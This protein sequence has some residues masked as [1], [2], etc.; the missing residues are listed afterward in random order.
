[1]DFSLC[2]FPMENGQRREKKKKR[3]LKGGE[4]LESLERI[5]PF[6][7]RW[8][9]HT[10][11]TNRRRRTRRAEH[12]KSI[13]ENLPTR[14]LFCF[15]PAIPKKRSSISFMLLLFFP[16]FLYSL[17]S[18]LLHKILTRRRLVSKFFFLLFFFLDEL[19]I[20]TQYIKLFSLSLLLLLLLS[21]LDLYF[22]SAFMTAGNARRNKRLEFHF[23]EARFDVPTRYSCGKTRH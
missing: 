10:R 6:R 19:S 12:Q 23:T 11:V 7:R 8:Q 4:R 15:I 16:F 17:R 22:F 1:M 18:Y 14:S 20:H 13:K 2:F 9:K 3:E 5:C 21:K